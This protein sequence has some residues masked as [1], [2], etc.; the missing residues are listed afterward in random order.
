MK[1]STT[2]AFSGLLAATAQ[3]CT[4]VLV[5]EVWQSQTERTRELKL[6]D[7][8]SVSELYLPQGAHLAG[9]QNYFYAGGYYVTMGNNNEGGIVKYLNR[10][11][12]STILQLDI[13]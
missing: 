8:D 10:H 4:R 3:A 7:N 2:I 12:K 9:G 5:N 13:P 1:F 6:W 11:S